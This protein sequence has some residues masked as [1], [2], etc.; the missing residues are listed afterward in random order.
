MLSSSHKAHQWIQP[1]NTE[2]RGSDWLCRFEK[3]K[4]GHHHF[5][6]ENDKF[7]GRSSP[8]PNSTFAL[9]PPSSKLHYTSVPLN[10]FGAQR[11]FISSQP[12]SSVG[13]YALQSERQGEIMQDAG[14]QL[15]ASF[16][17]S[18]YAMKSSA[19]WSTHGYPPLPNPYLSIHRET[20]P[21]HPADA[22]QQHRV[23]AGDAE[24]RLT[25]PQSPVRSSDETFCLELNYNW[26]CT[27]AGALV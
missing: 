26:L 1:P 13:S 21:P 18:S 8:V 9:S 15:A 6:T 19:A 12:V 4:T 7:T 5:V 16:A 24:Q 25:G 14:S 20:L 22:A 11:S 3:R 23:L 10:P 17:A 2:T 27:V